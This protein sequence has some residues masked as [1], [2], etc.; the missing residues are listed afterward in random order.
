[1]C[2]IDYIYINISEKNEKEIFMNYTFNLKPG[3]IYSIINSLYWGWN[4]DSIKKSSDRVGDSLRKVNKYLNNRPDISEF[5]FN[6]QS[7]IYKAFVHPDILWVSNSI[8]DYL[9]KI[10]NLEELEIRKMLLKTLL[11]GISA[12]LIE[13][14]KRKNRVYHIIKKNQI[15]ESL[16]FILSDLG[17]D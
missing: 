10:E 14:E 11:P 17:L 4:Y 13:I 6:N 9:T 12:N 16:D 2:L 8:E 15:K 3:K 1:M 5:L 7:R